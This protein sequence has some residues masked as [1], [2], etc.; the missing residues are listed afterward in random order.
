MGSDG[1]GA[2]LTGAALAAAAGPEEKEQRG[3][4]RESGPGRNPAS[5]SSS[6]HFPVIFPHSPCSPGRRSPRLPLPL[7]EGPETAA[8]PAPGRPHHGR[9]RN[10]Q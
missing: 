3:G 8:A 1:A 7:R 9:A 6:R 2:A 5:C 10:I 4:C